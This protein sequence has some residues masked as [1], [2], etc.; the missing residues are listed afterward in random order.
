M[1]FSPS[2]AKMVILL[3]PG[4]G[5]RPG[6]RR[7]EG[8]CSASPSYSCPTARATTFK[9][10]SCTETFRLRIIA[11]LNSKHSIVSL[12][13]LLS[14][15]TFIIEF[16][17]QQNGLSKTSPSILNTDQPYSEQSLTRIMM[18]MMQI[19]IITTALTH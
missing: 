5:H 11:L 18:M 7:L 4:G 1:K 3:F 17:L 2:E 10:L 12:I 14:S 13:F 6:R 16:P 8:I 9:T 15:G 19:V